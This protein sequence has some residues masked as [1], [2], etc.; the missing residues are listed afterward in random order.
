MHLTRSI[1]EALRQRHRVNWH[2][3]KEDDQQKRHYLSTS[4]L[5]FLLRQPHPVLH[6]C[7]A[8]KM[9]A[10][11][12]IQASRSKCVLCLTSMRRAQNVCFVLHPGVAL[13][14]CALSYIQASRSKCVLCLT[15]MRRAQNV[16]FVLHP[17]VALKMCALSYIQASRSKCV[18]CLTSMRRA[19]NVCFVLHPGVALKMCALS[20]SVPS[21]VDL[22]LPA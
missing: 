17:G 14:M 7:V 6:P 13:K 3:I 2:S 16:C 5:P 19:Q 18:L 21:M 1:G 9:R 22:C 12:Y 4:L 15:S 20:Y 10:L 11:S 8:L